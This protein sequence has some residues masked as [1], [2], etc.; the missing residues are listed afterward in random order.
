MIFLS[1]INALR[2][3]FRLHP[4]EVSR[5]HLL[6][7]SFEFSFCHFVNHF[8]RWVLFLQQYR[9]LATLLGNCYRT[10]YNEVGCSRK[11]SLHQL[12]IQFP[13]L[14]H[15]NAVHE[16]QNHRKVNDRLVHQLS[17]SPFDHLPCSMHQKLHE[18]K[19]EGIQRSTDRLCK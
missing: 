9:S 14:Q 6:L 16:S 19:L 1:C 12:Q 15:P 13:K 4:L 3:Y 7:Q 2:M 17:N 8:P 5:Y 11:I 10:N 18:Q